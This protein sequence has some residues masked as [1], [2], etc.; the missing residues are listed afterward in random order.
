MSQVDHLPPWRA[1]LSGFCATLVGV[2]LARFA[3]TPLL[4]ALIAAEW[5][6]A[7]VAAY[8][9]AANL[10]G[11]VAGALFAAPLAARFPSRAVLRCM[12]LLASASLIACAW[13]AVRA[14][15]ITTAA[16]LAYE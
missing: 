6:S 4:P 12:M 7:S 2:G 5:F 1:T 3:Y 15:R 8:L 9:A 13:P 14:T 10:A 11:Y 16:A